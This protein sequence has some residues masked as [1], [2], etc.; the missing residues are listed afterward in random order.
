MAVR[1]YRIRSSFARRWIGVAYR[2]DL[3]AKTFPVGWPLFFPSRRAGG[4]VVPAGR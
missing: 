1:H 2:L 4:P 3:E